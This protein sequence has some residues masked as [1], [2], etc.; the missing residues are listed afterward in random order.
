M[1]VMANSDFSDMQP[2]LQKSFLLILSVKIKYFLG[3]FK[4]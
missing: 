3:F 1:N 2:A 4:S